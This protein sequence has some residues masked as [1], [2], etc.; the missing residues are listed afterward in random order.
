MT[1]RALAAAARRAPARVGVFGIGLAAYWDQFPG[2]RDKLTGNQAVIEQVLTGFG[3]QVVSAGLVDTADAARDAGALFGRSDLDLVFCYVG[4]YATSSQVLPAVHSLNRQVVILNLQPCAALDYE[5]ADTAEWLANCCAC[6]VPEIS[7]AFARARITI[8]VI[9]GQLSGD[10]RA[11]ELMRDWVLAASVRRAITTARVG[12]LGH[13]YPGMLDMYADFTALEAQLGCQVELLEID[14]LQARIPPSTDRSVGDKMAEVHATFDTAAAGTDRISQTVTPEALIWASQV[15]V[16]LDQLVADFRLNGL[17]YYYR[18]LA[19]NPS[20]VLGA[21]LILGNSLLTARGVPAAGE[22]DIKTCIAMLMLDALDAGG[23]FTE[24]YAMDFNEQFLLMGH[25]GPAHVG[26]ADGRPLMRGLGVLHGKRG[27][28]LSVECTVRTGP[29]TIAGLTQTRD[30]ALT[31]LVAEGHCI[32]GPTLA[33]GNTNSRL[34]FRQNPAQF[35]DAWCERGPT[36]HVALG[37]GHQLGRLA[38]VGRMLGLAVE[39]V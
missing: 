36:H 21:S 38:K 9:S 16:G 29:I 32:S 33:I 5:H 34:Q 17:T 10:P 18:G 26:I 24:F 22:G 8:N 11:S 37:I 6:C 4:T 39:A 3:A 1:E 19:G 35:I 7:H 15:A 23:S 14:D 28:G 31:L 12:F 13:T 25:D 30:S 20:E 27:H 2:L